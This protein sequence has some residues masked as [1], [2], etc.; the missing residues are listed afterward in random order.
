VRGRELEALR[1]GIDFQGFQLEATYLSLTA[2]IATTAFRE[3]SLREQIRATRDIVDRRSARPA[4]REAIRARATLARGRARAARAA[5]A[6]T[7][8]PAAAREALA[9]TRNQLAVL[10]GKFPDEARLPELDLSAFQLPR[11]LP[12]SLPSDLVRQRP[13][14]RAPKPFC[15]RPTRESAWRRRSCFRSD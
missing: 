3:A 5:C 1:A 8:E 6:D 4:G 12:V 14:I 2:N 15:A 9:Q 10:I 7:R 11:N 13:D